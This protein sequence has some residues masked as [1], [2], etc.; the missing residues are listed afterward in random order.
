MS[1][2]LIHCTQSCTQLTRID[3]HSYINDGGRVQTIVNI[4]DITLYPKDDETIQRII[5]LMQRQLADRKNLREVCH[6]G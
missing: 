5:E 2:D 1:D 4:G 6:V 3:G